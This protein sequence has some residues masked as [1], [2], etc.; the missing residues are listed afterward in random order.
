M[1]VDQA[2]LEKFDALSQRWWD[3]N[4]EM[5]PLHEIN[6]LRIEWIKRYASPQGKRVLDVGCGG[7]ILAE[8]LVREGA[9]VTG[10]DLAEKAIKVAELHALDVGLSMRYECVA[11]DELAGREPGSYDMV[12]CM[13]MLEHVPDPAAIVQSCAALLKPDGRLF[14][15]TLNRHPK[16]FLCAVVGAEYILKLLPQGTHDFTK[17]ITPAELARYARAA[18]LRV[19]AVGGLS[20][21]PLTGRHRLTDNTD[22]NYLM[23][24]TKE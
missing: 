3:P 4:A 7:G 1:N 9:Q 18:G 20:Y 12:T 13:E 6:P 5:R 16:A 10:I 21:N 11:V 23:A 8:G 2:E 22:I 15:S 14:L 24:C 19:D 17:F